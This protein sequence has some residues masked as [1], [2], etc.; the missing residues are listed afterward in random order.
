[1]LYK[2]AML[3]LKVRTPIGI[4]ENSPCRDLF[5]C[6]TVIKIDSTNLQIKKFYN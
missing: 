4:R 3:S 1:M 2:D 6:K 5:C